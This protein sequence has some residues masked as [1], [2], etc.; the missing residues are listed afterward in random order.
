MK[1]TP[2]SIS[3]VQKKKKK[4]S[5]KKRHR[6]FQRIHFYAKRNSKSAKIL[7]N[8]KNTFIFPNLTIGFDLASDPHSYVAGGPMLHANVHD[9]LEM[10]VS[11]FLDISGAQNLQQFSAN[12]RFSIP[13]N[14]HD[15]FLYF[16]NNYFPITFFKN[17]DFQKSITEIPVF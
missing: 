2:S 3:L 13:R 6:S 9:N 11:Y 12:F 17:Q 5:E 10:L 16:K 8:R 4:S 15:I 14:V 7:V 1:I